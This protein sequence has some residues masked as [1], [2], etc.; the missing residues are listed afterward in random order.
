MITQLTDSIPERIEMISSES[1][2]VI[3]DG[4]PPLEGLP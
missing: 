1:T 4:L 2:H 3:S